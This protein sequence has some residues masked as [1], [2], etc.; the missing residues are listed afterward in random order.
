MIAFIV[1]FFY[2]FKRNNIFRLCLLIILVI[3]L[4]VWSISLFENNLSLRDA[5]W[6]S[7]V[8]VTTVGYGDLVPATMG[9]RI[10]AVCLMFFGIGFLGMFT[11]NVASIFVEWRLKRGKGMD[12]INTK[13]HFILC[14][15]NYKT[16]EIIDELK[17]DKTMNKTPIVL[18]ANI[19]EQPL[20][21]SNVSF[22][23]GEV[24]ADTM[25]R[26]NLQG[27]STV[28]IVSDETVDPH[29]RD[30]KVIM[31]ALTI[32]NLSKDIYMC[33]EISDMKNSHHCEIAG[34]DETIVIGELSSRLLVQSAL[35]PGVKRVFSE[36]MSSQYGHELYKVRAPGNIVGRR[37]IDAMCSLKEE[38]D[39]VIIAVESQED[40]K[41]LLNPPKDLAINEGD[42]LIVMAEERPRIN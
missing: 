16:E 26:S 20:E 22:V 17:A 35:N 19:P 23:R 32:R 11:A 29:T 30:A 8:T 42:Q 2:E 38:M 28:I 6:W 21:Y 18:V 9:G 3:L 40:K 31:D 39:A 15:W 27:A 1:R 37:F 24:N 33:V 34:A 5:F 4:G 41:I 14:G 12:S 13:K 7:V 10:V 25:E 36:L